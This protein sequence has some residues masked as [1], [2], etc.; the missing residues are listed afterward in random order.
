MSQ[1]LQERPTR[2]SL[3][4]EYASYGV[5]EERWRVGGE[6][7]RHL[8]RPDGQPVPYHGTHG[9]QWLLARMA[10]EGWRP[11]HEGEHIIELHR[12]DSQ[13]TLEPGGQFELSGTPYPKVSGVLE[14]ARTFVREVQ[15]AIGDAPIRQVALGFTPYARMEDI[16]WVPKGRYV[17]MREYLAAHGDLSHHMMKGTAAVQASF[18]FSDEA[19]CARKVRLAARLGPLVTAMFA[20]SPV[21]QGR[22]T[23]FASWRGHVWSRTDPART[24]FPPALLDFS[25]EGWLD[26]LLDVPMMF[27]R[28]GGRWAPAEGRTFRDWIDHGIDGVFPTRGDWDLHLTSVFPEVR[29]K[30]QI[31]VRGADCVPLPLSGAFVAL[32]QGLFYCR[33]V[34]DRATELAERFATHGTREERFAV[35]CRAGLRG[36]V[37]GRALADWAA[38]LLDLATTGMENCEPADLPRLAPLAQ[39][40]VSGES[41]ADG[42]LRAWERDPRP[43]A[44]LDAITYGA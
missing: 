42:V 20:N 4:A 9:V 16:S 14:Q 41:P 22:P 40:I 19:D 33:T 31:E 1:T 35:A 7:E 27:T 13:I 6:F 38:D 17:V 32:F 25:F 34:L 24:G 26:Y 12:Q 30:K 37:G 8:L 11:Y 5:P 29:V 21:A 15:D 10:E 28:V 39:Q 23:G 2:H 43:E 18:D 36:V 3:L 44:F